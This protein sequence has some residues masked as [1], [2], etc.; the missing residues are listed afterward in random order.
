MQRR[1]AGSCGSSIFSFLR[2]LHTVSTVAAPIHIATNSVGG[3]SF[4]HILANICYL[5]FF[6]FD[7]SHADSC[8]V[9]SHCGFDLRFL[10]D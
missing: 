10:D 3:F 9:I 2:G 7:D 6:F 4:V 8:E 5:C 1:I